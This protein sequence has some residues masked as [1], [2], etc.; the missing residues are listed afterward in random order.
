MKIK[1]IKQRRPTSIEPP[2]DPPMIIVLLYF[3]LFSSGPG[4]KKGLLLGFVHIDTKAKMKMTS[5]PDGLMENPITVINVHIER[6]QRSKKKIDFGVPFVQCKRTFTQF[7]DSPLLLFM[8]NLLFKRFL[9]Q[10]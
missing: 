9:L 10:T 7:L 2:L 8:I 1:E 6:R 5:L 3:P 4:E